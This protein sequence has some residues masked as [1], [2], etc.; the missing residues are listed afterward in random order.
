LP[1]FGN[2]QINTVIRLRDGETNMLAGLIRDDERRVLEGIPGPAI[3]RSSES[4]L[5]IRKKETAGTDIVLTLTRASSACWT[6]PKPT[7]GRSAWAATRVEAVIDLPFV[8]PTLP[9]PAPPAP[10]LP[11]AAQATRPAAA[12]TGKLR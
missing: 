10:N 11:P 1:T 12:R 5:P 6:S 2:R 9:T 3:F 7:C 8:T 4:C